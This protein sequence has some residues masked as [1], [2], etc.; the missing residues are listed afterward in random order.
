MAHMG[1]LWY[2]F[3]V[4]APLLPAPV[5]SD[6]PARSLSRITIDPWA[7]AKD[8]FLKSLTPHT[9][10]QYV[11]SLKCFAIWFCQW[12]RENRLRK[13]ENLP[14]DE[15]VR[16]LAEGGHGKANLVGLQWKT[17]LIA[18]P[19]SSS[20][21]NA[22]LTALKAY[23]KKIRFFGLIDW[24]LGVE[25]MRSETYRDTKGPGTEAFTKA[26]ALL[27]RMRDPKSVR[28]RTILALI[29]SLA[30]R[31]FEIATLDLEHIDWEKSRIWIKA[32]MRNSRLAQDVSEETLRRLRQ[33]VAIRGRAPGP[34]FTN[35][36]RTGKGGNRLSE[37]GIY[38][39]VRAT[40][41]GK[42]HGIRHQAITE[43]LEVT[44]G[45]IAEVMKFSRHRDPKTVMIYDDNRKNMSRAIS[46]KISALGKP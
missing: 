42:T 7:F 22:R 35:F 38:R 11:H 41:L 18:N 43:A 29:R 16:I 31:R 30:L 17:S 24:P 21:V 34:L 27:D 5:S 23:L 20:T 13:G 19:Y 14:W 44:N 6:P 40:G 26:L 45:N 46:E 12:L 15:A 33:W 36:D 25:Q 10:R 2:D 9:R 28:D 1:S 4:K 39:V 8:A 37:G 3:P 32:K